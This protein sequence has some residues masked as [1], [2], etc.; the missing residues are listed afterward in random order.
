MF[1]VSERVIPFYLPS[2]TLID[3]KTAFQNP[4]RHLN[5]SEEQYSLT[6]ESRLCLT[7]FLFFSYSLLINNRYIGLV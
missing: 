6:W 2:F 3:I 5:I 1:F 7:C 4:W